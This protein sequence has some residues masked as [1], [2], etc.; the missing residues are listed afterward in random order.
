M[1]ILPSS[2]TIK[3]FPKNF[4][5]NSHFP[6]ENLTLSLKKESLS[7]W[8]FLFL[9]PQFLSLC[10][11]S[12][13]LRYHWQNPQGEELSTDSSF[14]FQCRFLPNWADRC[15]GT[16]TFRRCLPTACGLAT[17]PWRSPMGISWICLHSLVWL[18]VL[19]PIPP[20]ATRSSSLSTWRMPKLPR[21]LFRVFFCVG[22]LSK[23]SLPDRFVFVL[24]FPLC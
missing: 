9:Q 6:L 15:T 16:R 18:I 17:Y 8:D 20:G 14:L 12:F 1:V 2:L 21:R 4:L 22:I 3:P 23:S 11:N 10:P 13:A 24:I 7:L 5:P 19:L